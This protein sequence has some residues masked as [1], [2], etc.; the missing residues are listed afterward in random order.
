MKEFDLIAV[1]GG[2][3]GLVTAAGGANLGLRVV[4]IEREAL[5]GDCLWTGCVPSKAMI[6]SAKLAYQMRNAERLGLVGAAPAH[7][8]RTVMERMRVARDRVSQHDDPERFRRMGIE[9]VFGSAE[10]KGTDRVSVDGIVMRSPRIVIATGSSPTVP[11]IPGLDELGYL[12]HMTAFDQN[13]LPPRIAMLGG[14]PIGLEFAQ[15][16]SRLGAEVTVLELLP[17][18]LPRED[19][20]ASRVVED[21]LK[22]EGVDVRTGVSLERVSRDAG[23]GK[24]LHVADP[25]GGTPTFTVDEIFV[26]TGRRANGDGFGLDSVGVELVDGA[27]RVDRT[28]RSS[29]PTVWAAGDVAGGL[30]YTHVADYQAKLVLRNSVFPFRTKANY[31]SVPWVTFTD[32]EVAGVGLTEDEA[33]DRHGKVEVFR[34]DFADLDRAIVEENTEGFVKVV[35]RSGGKILGATVVARGAGDVLMPLV[36]AMKRGIPLPKLSQI[37][38]PYPTM[39]EGVKRTADGYY[40]AKLSGRSGKLLRKVVRWLV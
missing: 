37:V 8:F 33:R 27:V 5:G 10:M 19:R 6:A 30:Q 22:T 24:I 32:P 25:S 7:V 29:L 2:T 12:T 23:G 13:E 31:S 1:G 20:E 16:Y 39:V 28:L 15:V 3:A 11:P 9:V 35:T 40:R 18:L 38:Y 14:G 34:Y 36:L 21:A 26:A 17:A 4:L